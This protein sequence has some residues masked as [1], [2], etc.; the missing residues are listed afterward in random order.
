MVL[1]EQALSDKMTPF[2]ESLL[3][4]NYC[5]QFAEILIQKTAYQD[6]FKTFFRIDLSLLEAEIHRFV[7]RQLT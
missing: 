2:F 3:K 6:L 7:K 4:P 5:Y 1:V